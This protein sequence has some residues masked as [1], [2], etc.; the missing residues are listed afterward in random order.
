[1]RKVD[2]AAYVDKDMKA[3]SEALLDETDPEVEVEVEAHV[4][5]IEVPEEEASEATEEN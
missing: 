4:E 2:S 5:E 3:L 1:M